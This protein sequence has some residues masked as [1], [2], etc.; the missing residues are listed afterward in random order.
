MQNVDFVEM[1]MEMRNG[2]V[3][4]EASAKLNEL[5]AAITDTGAGGTLTLKVKI[6][7][8]KV[9]LHEGV[10]EVIVSH[11]TTIDKPEKPIGPSVFF[12]KN[13]G[14]LTRTDPDQ[15]AMFDEEAERNEVKQNG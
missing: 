15:M 1:L 12:V 4:A 13:G 3:A 2:K 9:D 6:K 14:K 5:M 8:S 10:K 11:A 7:P